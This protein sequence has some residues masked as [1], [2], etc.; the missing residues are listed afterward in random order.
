MMAIAFFLFALLM[1]WVLG[2]AIVKPFLKQRYGYKA[3]ALGAGY[4]LGWF[5][6]TLILRIYDYF[7]RPFD[8]YEIVTIECI[9]A[10]P[11]LFLKARQCSIE[12]LRLEK[13]PSN[14]SYFLAIMIVVLLLY[15]LGLTAVDLLSKPVFPWDGWYSW[16]AKAKA[17][18]YAREISPLDSPHIGFWQLDNPSDT[19]LVG[20]YHHPYFVSLIQSYTAM[21]WGMWSDNIINTPWLGCGIAL[22]L[23]IFGGLRYLGSNLLLATMACYAV[24]SLPMLDTHISLGSYADLW[25]GLSFLILVLLFIV[26]LVYGENKLLMLSMIFAIIIYLTKHNALLFVVLVLAFVY[27]WYLLGGIASTG[28]LFFLCTALFITKDWVNN[29]LAEMLSLLISHGFK[30]IIVYNPV[31]DLAWREWLRFDNW[32]YVFVAGLMSVVLLLKLK[33]R[34]HHKSGFMLLI[35]AAFSSLFVMLIITFFTTKMYDIV[36]NAYFN[37][38]SLYFMPVFTLISVSV[39]HL[40]YKENILFLDDFSDEKGSNS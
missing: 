18:Y 27:C 12:E 30:I 11:L 7:Q 22:A 1:P 40:I 29:E 31:A 16:S 34:N 28:L 36:F 37:R 2:F 25:V 6:T 21:A 17:F 10:F 8:I 39:Y 5:A 3:F 9:V 13:A 20:G 35:V 15:R 26:A 14:L 4:V 19:V 33:R 32:H 24:V 23:C 38:A